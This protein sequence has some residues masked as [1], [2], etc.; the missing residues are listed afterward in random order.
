MMIL[1]HMSSSAN[2]ITQKGLHCARTILMSVRTE[3]SKM[4]NITEPSKWSTGYGA[5]SHKSIPTSSAGYS[6]SH[7]CL[8][9]SAARP[10][11]ERALEVEQAPTSMPSMVPMR[12]RP[13]TMVTDGEVVQARVA[14]QPVTKGTTGE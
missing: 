11:E 13:V 14:A 12:H 5:L 8:S 1:L 3:S 6:C 9:C 7:V 4:L 10:G 2:T